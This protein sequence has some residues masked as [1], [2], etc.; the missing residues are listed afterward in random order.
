MSWDKG[1]LDG[2]ASMRRCGRSTAA[3]TLHMCETRSALIQTARLQLVFPLFFSPGRQPAAAFPLA[4][5]IYQTRAQRQSRWSKV[6]PPPMS[7]KARQTSEDVAR[8]AQCPRTF[9]HLDTGIAPGNGAARRLTAQST[10]L[11]GGRSHVVAYVRNAKGTHGSLHKL[12]RREPR[13]L[14][15][16]TAYRMQ[17]SGCRRR[18]TQ[19]FHRPSGESLIKLPL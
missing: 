16:S 11:V 7:G 15:S 4:A 17:R 5:Q 2:R 19:R 9:Y 18:F 1:E 12:G 8:H 13:A 14:D 6:G 10:A 3:R